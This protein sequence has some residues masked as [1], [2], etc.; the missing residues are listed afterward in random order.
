[1]EKMDKLNESIRA[2]L[3]E[4]LESYA[5]IGFDLEGNEVKLCHTPTD[6][7]VRAVND[8]Y[9]EWYEET[10]DGAIEGELELE[11]WQMEEG[12]EYA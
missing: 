1:M 12:D 6:K 10:V 7:D 4:R 5:L 3:S 8:A 9:R 11:G 2:V